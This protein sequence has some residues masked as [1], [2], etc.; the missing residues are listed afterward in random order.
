MF[1]LAWQAIQSPHTVQIL[2][3]LSQQNWKNSFHKIG[4]Q[5]HCGSLSYL[6]THAKK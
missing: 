5:R 1:H 2:L 3:K 4:V 6:G